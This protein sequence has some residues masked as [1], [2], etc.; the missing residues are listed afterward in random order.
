MN[1]NFTTEDR[2]AGTISLYRTKKSLDDFISFNEL[3]PEL[4]HKLIDRIEIKAN[5]GSRIFYRFSN[6]SVYSLLLTINAQH[7][8]CTVCG[9]RTHSRGI[10]YIP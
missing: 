7:S 4:L 3:T 10:C 9:K 5:G 1:F 8:T 2:N 6:P